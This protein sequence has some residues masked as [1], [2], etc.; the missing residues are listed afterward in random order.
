MEEDKR[1]YSPS[2]MQ[3]YRIIDTKIEKISIENAP[4]TADNIY[5]ASTG[6]LIAGRILKGHILL[7]IVHF[8]KIQ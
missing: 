1:C 3:L 5:F 8:P 2:D 7:D 4:I 6:D